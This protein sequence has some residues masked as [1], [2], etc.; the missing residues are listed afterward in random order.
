MNLNL[1]DSIIFFYFFYF[2]S[3][4]L[5]DDDELK[6]FMERSNTL[7]SKLDELHQLVFTTKPHPIDEESLESYIEKLQVRCFHN[8][9][10]LAK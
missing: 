4:L 9:Y 10:Y 1:S 7:Q 6:L 3:L 2:L 8:F 5:D